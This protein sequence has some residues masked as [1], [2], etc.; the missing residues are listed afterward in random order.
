MFLW[1]E[2]SVSQF[3]SRHVWAALA[4]VIRV[5][6]EEACRGVLAFL[7]M[8]ICVPQQ[9]SDAVNPNTPAFSQQRGGSPGAQHSPDPGFPRPCTSCM[10]LSSLLKIENAQFLLLRESRIAL[11]CWTDL[12]R[13]RL[14]RAA[15]ICSLLSS[16]ICTV[17]TFFI[18]SAAKAK[19]VALLHIHLTECPTPILT[20]KAIDLSARE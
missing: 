14:R 10:L 19:A 20:A 15:S 18:T 8:A 17:R 1:K 3:R 6:S 13:R 5:C 4:E 16:S 11:H 12:S 7:T 9:H 2:P